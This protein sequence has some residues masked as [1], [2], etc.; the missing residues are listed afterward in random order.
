[1]A[2]SIMAVIWAELQMAKQ[3]CIVGNER[4]HQVAGSVGANVPSFI[5]SRFRE[6]TEG[7][8]ECSICFSRSRKSRKTASGYLATCVL[9]IVH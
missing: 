6:N 3:K 7:I 5:T 8:Y 9:L 4:R 1:M 2:E